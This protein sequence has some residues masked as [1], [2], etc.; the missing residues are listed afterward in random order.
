MILRDQG[1]QNLLCD[2]QVI[3]IADLGTGPGQD[4]EAVAVLVE[5]LRRGDCVLV[6]GS[7]GI[8]TERVVERL[9]RE[10]GEQ[11]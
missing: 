3:R 5:K 4:E 10:F 2:A 9:K 6:K 1:R 11:G 8:R 7:R